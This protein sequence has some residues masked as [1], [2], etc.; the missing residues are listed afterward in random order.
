MK[1]FGSIAF[2]F[3]LLLSSRQTAIAQSHNTLIIAGDHLVLALDLKSSSKQLDS[4]LKVAGINS[5]G[6]KILRGDFSALAND[7]WKETKRE[8]NLVEFNRSLSGLNDNSQSEPYRITTRLPRF[9]GEPGYPEKVKFGIN[10]YA[11][12]TVFELSSGLTRFILPGYQQAKRVFL[13]G[14]F[15]NWS[16]LQGLM[17]KLDGGWLIDIKL[18]PGVYEYKYIVDGRWRTDPNNLQEINDGAG[19]VNSLYFKY[20]YTFKLAGYP[21]AHRV[22]LTGDF[23]SWDANQIILERKGN[24]WQRQLFLDD[25]S[26]TYH[27]LVDALWIT[28][29]A[30]PNKVK[31]EDG[32]ENSVLN[33]GETLLFKLMGYPDAKKVFLA[34]NFNGWKP[35]ELSMQKTKNGWILPRTLPAGNYNYKFIVDGNWITDPLN[36]CYAVEDGVTN[37]FVAVKPNHTFKLKGHSDIKQ[38]KLIGTFSK[39]DD[40]EYTLA[41][42]GD[43]WTIDLYLKPGKYLY[44]FKVNHQTIK[45]PGNKLYEPGDDNND[46]SVLWME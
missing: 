37:S 1:F 31:D 24:N 9:D 36:P 42:K 2:L 5:S 22:I 8:N 32:H 46:N 10:N 4:V 43:E 28:D 26:H 7:G 21:S 14:N 17:K 15:N 29:P 12:V 30:N 20:N 33:F 34:G 41:H 23:N 16:T 39:W 18:A 40:G 6:A 3:L 13:S 38:V 45:D 19:N 11:K 35:G 25:G 27:Y 44:K